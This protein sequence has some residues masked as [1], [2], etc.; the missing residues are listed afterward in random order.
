MNRRTALAATIAA[1]AVRGTAANSTI[2]VGLLGSGNRGPYVAGHLA[3]NTPAKVV[4]LCDLS[5]ERMAKAKRT[6]GAEG[7]RLYTDYQKMLESDIDAIIIATPVFL[8]AEHFE[9]AVKA[10]KHIYIEKPA[11]VDVA[12]CKRIMRVADS[13]DRKLNITFGFQR[14]YAELYLKGKQI[15]DSGAIGKIRLG[16]AKFIKSEGTRDR[17][18]PRPQTEREKIAQWGAWK[19]LSGDLI[20]ENNIHSIDVLNWFLGARPVSAIGAGGTTAKAKGDSRDHNFVAYEYPGGVQGQL[21]GTTLAPPGYR[22]VSELFYGETGL[23]ETSENFL[24]HFKGPG[25]ETIEKTPRNITI[26]SVT[27]FVRRIAENKPEN[28]AVRG[29]ESTLTAILGRMAMDARREVTWDEM[30]KSA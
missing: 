6:I 18:A 3:K 1:A 28:T 14:R 26:D 15:V 9:A 17:P 19:D 2:N 21:N 22:D 25:N 16:H 24:R 27:E 23:I 12:G 10:G 5:E 11:S 20:V 30:M 13:A 8:H 4:A 7:A 29:A